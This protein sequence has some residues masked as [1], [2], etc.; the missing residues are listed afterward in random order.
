MCI[1]L[2]NASKFRK[3]FVL[4]YE[5]S[6]VLHLHGA[7]LDRVTVEQGYRHRYRMHGLT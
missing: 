7:R 1:Y 3:A 6:V 2:K 5:A 4:K